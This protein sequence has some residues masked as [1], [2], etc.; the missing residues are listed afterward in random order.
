MSLDLPAAEAALTQLAE[1]A[2]LSARAGVTPAQSNALGVVDVVNP[3]M[4]RAPRVIPVP[5]GHDP[6]EFTLISFGGAG[7]L[8]AVELAR[9]LNIPRVLVPPGASTLSAFGMLAAD[10]V[11][12]YVQTL[13][14]PG[15][16]PY[17]ELETLITP[18]TQQG[19]ADVLAEGVPAS[20]IV[21][22][23][24]LDMR[25]RG[26]SYELTL[27]FTPNFANEFHTAHA[28]AYGYSELAMPVEIVN[29][30]LRAIG[31]LSRPPLSRSNVI[32][33]TQPMPFDYRPVVAAAGLATIPFYQGSGLQPGQQITGPA[34]ITQPDTTVFI[35]CGDALRV[36]GYRNFVIDVQ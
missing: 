13:M 17:A 31:H 21:V 2:G 12:D 29:L 19:Q 4:G 10:V 11:K 35:D 24:L 34:V 33:E 14:R 25:Y 32:D 18:L 36:D 22:E 5:R 20:N 23:R 6:R 28:G 27:P 7:S 26:Q 9:S 16:T 1:Q 3:H 30:R 15:N 8:H